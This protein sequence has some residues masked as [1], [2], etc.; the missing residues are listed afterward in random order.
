[1]T[2]L[3]PFGTHHPRFGPDDAP[4]FGGWRAAGPAFAWVESGDRRYVL[5]P[6]KSLDGVFVIVFDRGSER[7]TW[8]RA[9][10]MSD[11]GAAEGGSLE[12]DGRGRMRVRAYG[13]HR[14]D[15][16]DLRFEIVLS[17]EGEAEPSASERT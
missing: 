14:I 11:A 9:L 10:T 6:A 5:A 1:M 8:W 3:L 17:P 16:S 2:S 15:D 13:R 12:V 4:V 7:P